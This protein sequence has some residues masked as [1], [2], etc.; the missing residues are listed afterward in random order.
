MLLAQSKPDSRVRFVTKKI[1][2]NNV[3]FLR[4]TGDDFNC[5]G[6]DEFIDVNDVVLIHKFISAL[7]LAVAP[8]ET[9]ADRVDTIE[10]HLNRKINSKK[11]I[12]FEFFAPSAADSYGY[13]FQAVLDDLSKYEAARTREL[14]HKQ[15][16][17]VKS[18]RINNSLIQ[19]PKQ[20]KKTLDFLEQ[21][22]YHFFAY[23]EAEGIQ[24]L[25]T[26]N[27]RS[28]HSIQLNL[29]VAPAWKLK[30]QQTFYAGGV[31]MR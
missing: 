14:I 7:Q 16:A 25:I 20:L 2:L 10:I 21:V 1:K 31:K 24:P 15:R 12:A 5:L 28:N 29:V 11:V 13:K 26:L 18:I 22:D 3:S 6:K 17:G 4:F 9:G 30:Y 23:T 19:Q 8:S 27:L